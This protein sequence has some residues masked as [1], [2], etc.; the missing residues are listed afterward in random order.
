MPRTTT[1]KKT[2][3]RPIAALHIGNIADAAGSKVLIASLDK[4][5][6]RAVELGREA[7]AIAAVERLGGLGE[8]KNISISNNV[9]G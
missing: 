4:I 2:V 3:R 9:I 7:V 5:A 1:K 8:I 6:M